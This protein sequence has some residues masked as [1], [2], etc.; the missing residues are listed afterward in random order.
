MNAC[1]SHFH[2]LIYSFAYYFFVPEKRTCLQKNSVAKNLKNHLLSLQ[3]KLSILYV[4]ISLHY[5]LTPMTTRLKTKTNVR[6]FFQSPIIFY[7]RSQ[8]DFF[9]GGGKW[10]FNITKEKLRK[11]YIVSFQAISMN[12]TGF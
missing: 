11:S 1:C 8:T 2:S 9:W 6:F 7:N 10:D 3:V 12:A 5:M 4:S